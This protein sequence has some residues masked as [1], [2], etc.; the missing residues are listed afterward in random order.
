[1]SKSQMKIMLILFDIKYIA[2]FAFIPQ[3]YK[4]STELIMWKY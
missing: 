3:G 1:M 2:N 4:H